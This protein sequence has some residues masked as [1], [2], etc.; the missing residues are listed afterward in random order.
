MLFKWICFPIPNQAG[1][2]ENQK[3]SGTLTGSAR[4]LKY[5]PPSKANLSAIRNRPE[6]IGFQRTVPRN[7]PDAE[8]QT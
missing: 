2:S 8:R 3:T 4:S 6:K 5:D 1:L 7:A